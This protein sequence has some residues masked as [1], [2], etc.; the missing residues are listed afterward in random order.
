MYPTYFHQE[1]FRVV[2]AIRGLKSHLGCDKTTALLEDRLYR[3]SLKRDISG[4]VSQY[5]TCQSG[6][7]KKRKKPDFIPLY[8]FSINP[9]KI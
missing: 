2:N 5:Y 6:K 9:E 4:V 7:A 3:A 8:L 1:L